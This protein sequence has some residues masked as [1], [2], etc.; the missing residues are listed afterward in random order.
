MKIYVYESLTECGI[1]EIE[2]DSLCEHTFHYRVSFIDNN[3][4]SKCETYWKECVFHTLDEAKAY[5]EQLR[6]EKIA[7]LRNKI[8][9]LE[10][11]KVGV[12]AI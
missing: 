6:L 7:K 5:A 1:H 11:L 10:Q 2:Y 8:D 9:H 12:K 3:G 4:T